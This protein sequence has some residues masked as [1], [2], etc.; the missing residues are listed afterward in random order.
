MTLRDDR[1]AD[2][3][4]VDDRSG[5]RSAK[6]SSDKVRHHSKSVINRRL[7]SQLVVSSFGWRSSQLVVSSFGWRSSQLVVSSSSAGNYIVQSSKNFVV[8]SPER[9]FSSFMSFW[10]KGI[11]VLIPSMIYSSKARC[12]FAMASSRVWATV[13]NFEIIES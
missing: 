13:I 9:N 8:K 2:D 7:S 10:W 6:R 3:H 1:F 4:F 5:W 11:V 12:I